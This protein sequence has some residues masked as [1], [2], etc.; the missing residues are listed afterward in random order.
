MYELKSVYEL[1]SAIFQ[2]CDKSDI[3]LG[4]IDVSAIVARHIYH[5]GV[6]DPF[7]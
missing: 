4:D 3:E 6:R 2:I 1:K 7:G 5:I